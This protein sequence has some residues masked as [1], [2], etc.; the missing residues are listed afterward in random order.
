MVQVIV[1]EVVVA[2]LLMGVMSSATHRSTQLA[3]RWVAL[4]STLFQ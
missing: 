3:N 1:K 2:G 4:T